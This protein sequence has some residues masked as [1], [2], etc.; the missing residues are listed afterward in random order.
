MT[1]R[2]IGWIAIL[3][4]GASACTGAPISAPVPAAV[5]L[6]RP[7]DPATITAIRAFILMENCPGL[8]SQQAKGAFLRRNGEAL[9]AGSRFEDPT[10]TPAQRLDYRIRRGRILKRAIRPVPR[11]DS[12]QARSIL[13]A[14]GVRL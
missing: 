7:V 3:A 6:S 5:E 12:P 13:N 2:T 14:V 9:I 10:L 1:I 8:V 11:C 4:A